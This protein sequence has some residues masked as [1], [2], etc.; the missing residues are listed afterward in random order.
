METDQFR[1]W[2]SVIREEQRLAT[3]LILID[4]AADVMN[5]D[6][7]D[8]DAKPVH[9]INGIERYNEPWY[10]IL[11]RIVPH[12][13]IEKIQTPD[14]PDDV[15]VDGW[16]RIVSCIER[17]A[18]GLSLPEGIRRP[19][20]V[21]TEELRHR[22]WLQ[23]CCSPLCGLGQTSE[24]TLVEEKQDWRIDEFL[25]RLHQHRDSVEFLGLTLDSLLERCELPDRDRP[26]LVRRVSDRF[27]L[28]GTGELLAPKLEAAAGCL[29]E[30]EE[31]IQRLSKEDIRQAIL[32]PEPTVFRAAMW[33]FAGTDSRDAGLAPVVLESMQAMKDDRDRTFACI[34]LSRL[35]QTDETSERIL[36]ELK[37]LPSSGDGTDHYRH[38]FASSLLAA[39]P[40]FLADNQRNI[41]AAMKELDPMLQNDVG[42]R[43]DDWRLDVDDRWDTFVT[44]IQ[45]DELSAEIDGFYPRRGL[46]ERLEGLIRGMGDDERPVRWVMETLPRTIN[47]EN[48][49]SALELIA[50]NLS[51][52][53]RR[54][55]SIP[56][57]IALLH[58][59]D[60]EMAEYAIRSLSRIGGDAVVE[61]LDRRF[62]NAE[63]YF[64]LQAATVLQCIE[65][66][67]SVRTLQKWSRD[68]ENESVQCRV[69]QALLE[70]FVILE[71]DR[72]HQWMVDADPIC[73]GVDGLRRALVANAL[74]AG[75]D[76]AELNDWIAYVREDLESEPSED[77]WD[78]GDPWCDDEDWDDDSNIRGNSFS[79]SRRGLVAD[80]PQPDRDLSPI[81]ETP[82]TPIINRKERV[83]R[84]DPCPCGSGKKYKKCCLKKQ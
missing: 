42:A 16:P 21:V 81:F 60:R 1:R 80:N 75:R 32:H 18:R 63:Q 34:C 13:P 14:V 72:T 7:P 82:A 64:Q 78:D 25:G 17:R 56:Y 31:P 5:F 23:V 47:E 68:A 73:E 67:R 61:A 12:L 8:V 39:Q 10:E 46:V 43:I 6:D 74:I 59:E 76:F 66:D 49:S 30:P 20:D 52:V 9:Y 70:Q 41:L 57:L 27:G 65:S 58:D 83:G 45:D 19:L 24:L 11:R 54:R 44:L 37:A 51:G 77:L 53:L 69:R 48:Y 4:R 40:S 29:D 50:V 79:L 28:G 3:M 22:L 26:I 36:Q 55:E 38:A 71:V 35:A 33:Y 15:L 84:N 62:V 2:E